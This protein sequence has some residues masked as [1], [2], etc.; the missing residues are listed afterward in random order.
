MNVYNASNNVPPV[1]PAHNGR[2]REKSCE[3]D[4]AGNLNLV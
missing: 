4:P 3:L 1:H 2:R